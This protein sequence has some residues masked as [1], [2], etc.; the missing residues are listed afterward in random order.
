MASDLLDLGRTRGNA[1]E[2]VSLPIAALLQ[3]MM[4]LGSSGSG[5][6]VLCKV[7]AEEFV[8]HGV[9]AL[10]LD[11]QGDLCSLALALDDPEQAAERGIDPELAAAFHEQADVVVFTPA[12]DKGIALGADP[13]AAISAGTIEEETWSRAA[14]MIAALLGYA[15]DDDDGAGL[16]AVLD[17]IMRELAEQDRAPRSLI[18]LT[19]ALDEITGQDDSKL[20]RFT[21]FWDIKKIRGAVQKLA[22]LEVGPRRRLFTGGIPLDIDVLLGRSGDAPTPAGKTRVAIVYLNSLHSQE[23]KEFLVAA[24]AERLYAWMLANAKP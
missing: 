5:K 19:A 11:P 13:L 8:R 1:P 2:P 10:I 4:A 3:H 20:K 9:P 14:G 17:T 12:S 18:E 16:V 6:T 15:V 22:R 7:V 21:K 23:D 24:I